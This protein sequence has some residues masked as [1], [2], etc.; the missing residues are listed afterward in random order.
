MTFATELA[1]TADWTGA[2][3]PRKLALL[4]SILGEAATFFVWGVCLF[5]EGSRFNKTMWTLTYCGAGMGGAFGTV[6]G[7]K[8][9]ND[10]GRAF[11]P[12]WL[13]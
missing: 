6:P 9:S 8:A 10:R 11:G 7:W 13:K 12:G 3:R 4:F 5:R 2:V 1:F